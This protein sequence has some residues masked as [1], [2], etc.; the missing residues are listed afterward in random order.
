[1]TFNSLGFLIFYPIVLLL[2][3]VLPKKLTKYML[4]IASYY[5]YLAWNWKLAGL[6]IFTT[7]VSYFCARIIEKTESKKVKRLCIVLTLI[8]SLG[9]LFFFKYYNFIA[10]S[11]SFVYGL[12]TGMAND[13]TLNLV[14][15]V[16]I[17]FYTFQTLSYAIDVYRGDEKCERDFITYALY[18][19]FFPQLVAG[20]IERPGNLIPQ[21][22]ERHPLQRDN[23]ELGLQQMAL[24]FFKKIAIAD[25][26]AE[27][28]NPIFNNA[29]EA[30]GLGVLLG[31]VLSAIQIYCDFSGYS[32]IAIGCSR[33]MGIK[34]MQNFNEPYRARSIKDFWNRWHISLS[35]WLRDYLYFPLG[36]S[37][38]S[39]PK[40]LFNIFIVF[41]ASGLWHGANWTFVLWGVFHGIFRILEELL[42]T[43]R[44]KILSILNIKEENVGLKIFET[45]FTF[46][47]VCI[48]WI[49]FRANNISDLGTL[50]GKVFNSFGTFADT[51]KT[52]NLTLSAIIC[53]VV[54]IL[55]MVLFDRILN[56]KNRVY[57]TSLM[58]K[59]NVSWLVWIVAIAW[60]LLLSVGGASTFIYF[61]F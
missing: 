48:S 51:F 22:K 36:G 1:M 55:V 52:M 25:L 50:V 35:T 3:F 49:I 10:D 39:K 9:V 7:C 15:P 40:H 8:A 27:Y 60:M 56:D 31:S 33:I 28:V 42:K 13:W 34:L 19:S 58:S 12:F 41:L 5:F 21:L 44:Q 2:Y 43:P 45:I 17:S 46:I 23:V 11:A 29:N 14:L 59:T 47:I 37:R 61:Q 6:I 54:S 57:P 24:G 30:T 38:C 20:P 26:L 18:V 4:L 32:D 53:T 16:G